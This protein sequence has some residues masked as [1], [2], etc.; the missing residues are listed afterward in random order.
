M[1]DLS[2]VKKP[3]LSVSDFK[4][5]GVLGLINRGKLD[6]KI[7]A[8]D[9][10]EA[11]ARGIHCLYSFK[12]NDQKA[13]DELVAW[14]GRHTNLWKAQGSKLLWRGE[15]KDTEYA[16]DVIYETQSQYEVLMETPELA[17]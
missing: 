4:V 6:Y 16:M 2:S 10:E 14:F 1:V 13:L 11:K 7:I 15:I 3:I 8:L 5:I 9:V 12:K 17:Q